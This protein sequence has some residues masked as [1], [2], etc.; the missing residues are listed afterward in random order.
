LPGTKLEGFD[1]LAPALAAAVRPAMLHLLR[2]RLLE[3]LRDGEAI[4][5]GELTLSRRASSPSSS[6]TANARP[7]GTHHPKPAGFFLKVT[8]KSRRPHP[9]FEV[10]LAHPLGRL[11]AGPLGACHRFADFGLLRKALAAEL[12][13][14]KAA[15]PPF[16]ERYPR[17]CVDDARAE[18]T[19]AGPLMR[20][21]V[22]KPRG[23]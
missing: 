22:G 5:V 14:H 11:A 2:R 23:T 21:R 19:A 20:T 4:K 13:A 12:K 10:H 1:D 6:S 9:L 18:K 8:L 16:P 3:T 15:L 7:S 17:A